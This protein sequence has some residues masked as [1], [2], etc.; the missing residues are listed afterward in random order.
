MTVAP[1]KPDVPLVPVFVHGETASKAVLLEPAKPIAPHAPPTEKPSEPAEDKYSI[2]VPI[3]GKPGAR[4]FAEVTITQSADVCPRCDSPLLAS[5]LGPGQDIHCTNCGHHFPAPAVSEIICVS[6]ISDDSQILF[7]KAHKDPE[8][9][10]WGPGTQEPDSRSLEQL[11]AENAELRV[12]LHDKAKDVDVNEADAERE[13]IALRKRHGVVTEARQAK[14]APLIN[15]WKRVANFEAEPGTHTEIWAS[16][17]S[18]PV[19]EVS[20]RLANPG[21]VDRFT[22]VAVQVSVLDRAAET[23]YAQEQA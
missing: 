3:V 12:Q 17:K 6:A 9:R 7:A 22:S 13:N 15:N 18:L 1:A 11:N 19:S 20:V 21:N 5:P 14:L 10:P 16:V 23:L 4:L 8:R 2:I